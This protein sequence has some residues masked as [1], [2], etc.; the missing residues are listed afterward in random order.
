MLPLPPDG[1]LRFLFSQLGYFFS[2]GEVR[3]NI[4]SLV[5]Y[6]LFLLAIIALYTLLFH[7]LMIRYEGQQH[8]WI[9]GLYWVL[10]VM[11]TLGFGDITFQTDIG[12]VYSVVVLVSGILLLLVM[13][14]FIFIR[15]F[16]APWL[17]ARVRLRAPRRIP[18]G[19]ANHVIIC[20]WDS[21]A[22]GL[23]E[24]LRINRIPHYV[25]EPDHVLA[26]RLHDD[27]IPV[28]TGEIDSPSTYAQLR[29]GAARLVF[30]NAEDTV[31]TN[32]TLTIRELAP[33]VPIAAV[34]TSP[35]SVDVL[36]LS[37]ADHVLALPQRL[38]EHLANRV[39]A[40]HTRCHVIGRFHDLL[41]AEFPVHGTPLCGRTVPETRLR[42][43]A[44]VN[45]IGV[46]EQGRLLPVD[47]ARKLT[48]S[49]VVVVVGTPAEITALDELLIIYD[50]NEN[51]VLVLG[52]GKVGRSAAL[53]LRRQGIAVHLIER[54]PALR[55]KI[56]EAADQVFIGDAAD[57]QI[58][59]AAGLDEAPSVLLTTHD[60]AMNIYLAV[61]CRR[62]KPDV[63]LVSRVTH[64]RNVDAVLR[65]GAD[66]VL[67]YATLGVNSVMSILMGNDL[68]I[69]G[70][71]VNLFHA[72]VPAKFAGR[73]LQESAIGARTGLAVIA[74][75]QNGQ[76]MT[77][78]G[79]GTV[80]PAHSTIVTIGSTEQRKELGDLFGD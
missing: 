15:F 56:G 69:L 1:R 62:L 21:I 68:V 71:G 60:D 72:P 17:E 11:S 38:G 78:I 65:A 6:L 57:R 7:V 61:Y 52:G 76:I 44:H 45:V 9:S 46:W 8:S 42:E 28:V 14:P 79:P 41:I 22:P 26:G 29:V 80:F 33:E 74:I 23:V 24:R 67:S 31:N 39:N 47:R 13:L 40:G 10:V 54:N 64:E 43:H 27:G 18:G 59:S 48:E 53:A 3:R 37:G 66:F 25:V 58:L 20:R 77:E 2:E 75:E 30:A 36:E 49:S 19:T 32:I 70:E 63:R 34:V 5:K 50:T 16:Y 51:P 73:T 4:R 55:E 12:R 35:D